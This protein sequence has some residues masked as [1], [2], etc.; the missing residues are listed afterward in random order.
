MSRTWLH[1]TYHICGSCHREF[2]IRYSSYFK[3][4]FWKVRY[5]SYC[6]YELAKGVNPEDVEQDLKPQE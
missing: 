4:F 6:G 3:R 2:E 1:S 5:C